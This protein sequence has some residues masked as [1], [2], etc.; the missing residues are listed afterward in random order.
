MSSDGSDL[1]EAAEEAVLVA[2]AHVHVPVA[3]AGAAVVAVDAH[4]VTPR[5]EPLDDELGV[6]VR[7]EHLLGRSVELPCDADEG[8]LRV[9]NDLGRAASV[10]THFGAPVSGG[11]GGRCR[12]DVVWHRPEDLV[13]AAAALLG[14]P[15]VPLD[16]LG[17]EVED[18]RLEVHG[19]SLGVA[20][21][22][23]QTGVLEHLEVLGDRLDRD[24]VRLGELVDRRVGE[25][26]PG[27]H[28]AP[29]GV[30]QRCEHPR[31]RIGRHRSPN[32]FNHSVEH[33]PRSGPDESS[34][35]WLKTP[36]PGHDLGPIA[37]L[38]GPPGLLRSRAIN[39]R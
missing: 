32:V 39:N 9:G 30:C 5:P 17:H 7:A 37:V 31:E 38:D 27:N 6:G 15:A 36:W 16:P 1:V 19:A 29:R 12:A 33:N 22:A 24:V 10:G 28:V 34:T 23:H 13:E 26:E 3:T 21:A 25:G 35:F 2:V 11:L 20:G 18:L 4:L 8:N 14:L